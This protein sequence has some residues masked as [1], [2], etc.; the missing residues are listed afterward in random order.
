[1]SSGG[2]PVPNSTLPGMPMPGYLS[3]APWQA[4]PTYAVYAEVIKDSRK[5]ILKLAKD[6]DNVARWLRNHVGSQVT[7]Y[8]PQFGVAWTSTLARR[9]RWGYLYVRIPSRLKALFEPIWKAGYPI[10]VIISIPP[11]PTTPLKDGLKPQVGNAP[12]HQGGS[13]RGASAG[14]GGQAPQTNQQG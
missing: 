12:A 1:V 8:V 9:R 5:L 7:T 4:V 13:N 11:I 2:Q 6:G 14:L 10:P 3:I